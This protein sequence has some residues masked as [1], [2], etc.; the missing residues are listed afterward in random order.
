M[1]LT[2]GPSLFKQLEH[3]ILRVLNDVP[4]DSMAETLRLNPSLVII[5]GLSAFGGKHHYFHHHFHGLQSFL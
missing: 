4:Y 2:S 1:F 3:F 5:G